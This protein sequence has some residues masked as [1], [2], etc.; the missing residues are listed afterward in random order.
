MKKKWLYLILANPQFKSFLKKNLKKI[1]VI[2]GLLTLTFSALM[3]W[4]AVSAFQFVNNKVAGHIDL[5][6]SVESVKQLELSEIQATGFHAMQCWF[7]FQNLL[8]P[9]PWLTQPVGTILS[10][11]KTK[12]FPEAL[13]PPC[14]GESCSDKPVDQK[15]QEAKDFI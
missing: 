12:C 8:N 2:G 11:L 6:K 1:L 3:I 10:R 14:Q 13:K 7:G 4:V 9:E 5:N 15:P